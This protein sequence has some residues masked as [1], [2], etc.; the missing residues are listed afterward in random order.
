MLS[1]ALKLETEKAA[2][3]LPRRMLV[4]MTKGPWSP[5][6]KHCRVEQPILWQCV[7]FDHVRRDCQQ[8]CPQKGRLEE[9][10]P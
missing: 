10:L 7:G 2:A 5:G 9:D 6:T 4:V 8:K 1:K 3:R